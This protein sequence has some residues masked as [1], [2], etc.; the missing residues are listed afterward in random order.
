MVG[1]KDMNSAVV[2][3]TYFTGKRDPQARSKR[4][5]D[6]R[7][8]LK[9]H[10]K[11]RRSGVSA[12][13]RGAPQPDDFERMRVFY[14]SLIRVGCRVVIF[15]DQLSPEFTAQWTGP[16][17]AF[18]KC[19]LKTPRSVN[20]ERYQ[21]YLEWLKA[22]PDLEW[23]FMTD[24]F[25]VE[26]LRDPF[27]LMGDDRYDF[28][29]G[30]DP[31]EYNDERNGR[32]MI[33]A[34]GEPHYRDEIKLHAGTCGACRA[35]VMPLLEKMSKTFD[36]LTE[37]GELSN[38]NMAVYNKCVYDLFDKE[39]ILYGYPLNSRFKKYEKEGDF[40]IRHK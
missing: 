28:Y 19:Q 40:A 2:L 37:R 26:F 33:Q 35:N 22:H 8:R 31:G 30:G 20:D 3:T 14:E 15:H 29:S 27:D 16:H 17:V 10:F 6:L 9:V 11:T 12:E 18:E 32:K 24:L 39:R 4:K 25:D 1:K 7:R 38:L 13:M 36:Q 34:Y 21:C 23:I 5:W